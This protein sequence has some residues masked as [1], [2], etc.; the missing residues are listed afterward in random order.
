MGLTTHVR[1]HKPLRAGLVMMVS[2]AWLVAGVPMTGGQAWAQDD[3]KQVAVGLYKLAV[4]DFRKGN[5]PEA[6]RKLKEVYKLDPNP[7]ILYNIG[8]AY[9]EMGQ[10]ADAADYFQQAAA[11]EKLPEKLQ[12][13]IGRRLP[14]VLPAL[15]VRQ[16]FNL[17]SR[18]VALGIRQAEDRQREVFIEASQTP[19]DI[20][21]ETPLMEDPLFWTGVG[22]GAAGLGLLGGG[23]V[24]DLGLSDDIDELKSEETRADSART[25]ALQDDI[26]SGQ[27]LAT[28][29]YISGGVLLLGGGALLAYTLTSGETAVP[30][31]ESKPAAT[32]WRWSPIVGDDIVGITVGGAL[33]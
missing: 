27:T 7:I 19:D 6:L 4:A 10:L 31:A 2:V 20:P 32:G 30:E 16:A 12:A 1:W 3:Q 25:L 29:F 33:P 23:L 15:T 22:L 17:S 11:D 21:E 26:E 14:K 28:V 5:F 13:E 8:R 24:T 9:E 18:S